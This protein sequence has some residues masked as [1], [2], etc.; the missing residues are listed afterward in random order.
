MYKHFVIFIITFLVYFYTA[1]GNCYY[2]IDSITGEMHK[3][4]LT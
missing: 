1:P 4:A 2:Y 3:N